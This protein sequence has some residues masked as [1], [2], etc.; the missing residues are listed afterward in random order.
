MNS[1]GEDDLVI[2]RY[3]EISLNRG[4]IWKVLLL[5]LVTVVV[6]VVVLEGDGDLMLLL[7]LLPLLVSLAATVIGNLSIRLLLFEAF[8]SSSLSLVLVL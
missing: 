6:L 3:K 4:E 7:L 5:S 8:S 2:I 1:L